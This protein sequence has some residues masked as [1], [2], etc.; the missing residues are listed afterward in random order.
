MYKHTCITLY[1]GEQRTNSF[2]K[3]V[4][5]DITGKTICEKSQQHCHIHIHANQIACISV[6]IF[7]KL[8]NKVIDFW[9]V[10]YLWTR[11]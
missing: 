6:Y 1:I 10:Y 3:L 2:L 8:I 4:S 5:D 11:L 9:F 7:A